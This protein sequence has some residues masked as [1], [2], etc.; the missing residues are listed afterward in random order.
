MNIEDVK[1]IAVIGS[2][3]MGHGIAQV[4]AV[5]GYSVYMTDLKQEYLDSALLKVSESLDVMVKKG[6]LTPEGKEKAFNSNLKTT[7]DL[8]EAVNGAAVVIEAVPEIMDLKK[9]VFKNLSDIAAPDAILATNT[10]TMSI[11]EISSVVKNPGRFAGMHFFNPVTIMKLVEIIYGE[12][13][14]G[15]AVELLCEISR[16]CG[17]VPVKVLKDRPGFIVNRISAPNQ[18]LLSAI[19]D[20]GEISPDEVDSVMKKIG[21]KMAPFE[22]AD[23]VGLDVFSHTLEYYSETLSPQYKPG[24]YLNE[25][26]SKNELGMKTGK[27]IYDWSSGKAAIDTSAESKVISP[28]HFLSVQINEAVRVYKEGIASSKQD[29]DDAV[30]F[31]MNAF[32]GPFALAAG[33]EPSQISDT[34]NF[35]AERF[36]LT[37]L[38][39]EPEIL[40]GSFKSM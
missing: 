30:K 9:Q 34:L 2:G 22:T 21:V 17:K 6:K 4:C 1:K 23:F 10:S 39:P 32:A 28:V 37:I 20:E 40:D 31:G 19:L 18:A 15:D 35:L 27:G 38:K 36:G 33:M 16:K 26:I 5:A 29:I 24:R 14:N 11:S 25:K 13:S 12:K 3:A 7:L 8:N